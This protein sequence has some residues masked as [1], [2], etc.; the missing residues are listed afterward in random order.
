MLH[1]LVYIGESYFFGYYDRHAYRLP[2]F[3]RLALGV[4]STNIVSIVENR[5]PFALNPFN[6]ASV[7]NLPQIIYRNSKECCRLFGVP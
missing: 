5:T 7:L 2:R 4:V 6:S 1:R 3:A